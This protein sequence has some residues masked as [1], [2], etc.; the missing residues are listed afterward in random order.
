M[1][2][3]LHSEYPVTLSFKQ[4]EISVVG[5][6]YQNQPKLMPQLFDELRELGKEDDIAKVVAYLD[7]H[8]ESFKVN[9]EALRMTLKIARSIP[10]Y[11]P[12]QV[13]K[14]TGPVTFSPLVSWWFSVGG[15]STITFEVE[16]EPS[17]EV[18][19]YYVLLSGNRVSRQAMLT[20]DKWTRV[21]EIVIPHSHSMISMFEC[22]DGTA[23]AC[24]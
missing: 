1:N 13:M 8:G 20:D 16:D 14:I 10:G 9:T 21:D 23:T 11:N 22:F 24:N 7:K 5:T 15:R 18:A 3:N 2:F 17:G 4:G 12:L 6:W 19:R